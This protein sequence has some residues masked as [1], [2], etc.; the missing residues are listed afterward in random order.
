MRMNLKNTA[1]TLGLMAAMSLPMYAQDQQAPPPPQGAPMAGAPMGDRHM[2]PRRELH[3]LSDQLN[4]TSVQRDRILPILQDRDQQ[5][6][7]IRHNSSLN[8]DQQR[9][10]MR[11]AMQGARD[12]IMAHLTPEQQTQYQAMM[13]QRRGMM[14]QRG[15]QM[16]PPP[17]AGGN[18]PPP[19]Q[20]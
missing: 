17:D 11:V 3:R 10:Q 7:G 9:E 18:P 15:G 4:L 6:S 8:P 16:A 2:D 20:Q 13:Q 19:P 14:M 1:L 5:I 12:K